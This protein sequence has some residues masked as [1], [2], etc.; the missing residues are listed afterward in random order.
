MKTFFLDHAKGQELRG[1]MLVFFF[2]CL[3]VVPREC[4][5]DAFKWK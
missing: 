3:F 2:L 1:K 5:T 4:N